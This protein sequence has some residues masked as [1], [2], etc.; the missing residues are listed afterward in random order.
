MSGRYAG[1]F[2]GT[3]QG[4]RR[5]TSVYSR[6]NLESPCQVLTHLLLL[7]TSTLTKHAAHANEN[8]TQTPI[9]SLGRLAQ[10]RATLA[11]AAAEAVSRFWMVAPMKRRNRG[12]TNASDCRRCR[13]ARTLR[14]P[15]LYND[16]LTV[17]STIVRIS[18]C[19]KYKRGR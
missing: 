18:C 11:R 8:I 5:K 15:T 4:L 19:R 13:D 14:F 2:G 1:C 17:K 3:E 12:H 10:A 7:S 6:A 16:F 9:V